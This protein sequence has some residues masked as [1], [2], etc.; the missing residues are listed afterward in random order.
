MNDLIQFP[1]DVPE[2]EELALEADDQLSLIPDDVA[3]PEEEENLEEDESTLQEVSVPVLDN[4][5]TFVW[6]HDK[7]LIV[8]ELNES[9]MNGT[10]DKLMD[11]TLK[12][13]LIRSSDIMIVSTNYWQLNSSDLLAD[14]ICRIDMEETPL[15]LRLTLWYNTEE[16]FASELQEICTVDDLPQRTLPKLDK[17]LIPIMNNDDIEDAADLMWMKYEKSALIHPEANNPWNLADLM[18]LSIMP[19]RLFNETKVRSSLFLEEGSVLV[20]KYDPKSPKHETHGEKT[21]IPV[22]TIVLN[23]SLS[24]FDERMLDI[25]HECFHYENHAMFFRLQKMIQT[26]ISKIKKKKVKIRKDRIPPDVLGIMEYQARRG[27]YALMLPRSAFRT[28]ASSKVHEL[29]REAQENHTYMNEGIAYEEVIRQL[30]A[31]R[32]VPAW[33]VKRRLFQYGH[34]GAKGAHNYVDGKYIAP[35]AFSISPATRLI[36]TY[37][38]DRKNTHLLYRSDKKFQALMQSGDYVWVDGHICAN[39]TQF[40]KVEDGEAQLTLWARAHVDECCL[41]FTQKY[42]EADGSSSYE[43]GKLN[44]V[45]AFNRHYRGFLDRKGVLSDKEYIEA[46]NALVEKVIPLPFPEMLVVLMQYG[47]SRSERFTLE[48]LAEATHLS[49]RTITRM[50]TEKRKEYRRDYVLAVCFAMHLPSWLS[51]ILLEKA[52]FQIPRYGKD[53]YLG[54]L[55]D[56]NFMD[57]VD[58]IQEYLAENHLPLLEIGDSEK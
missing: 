46:K 32:H 26:D 54:E 43:F 39:S 21:A 33:R 6:N 23:T 55:L 29:K 13:K 20:Q 40:I 38:I 50:R 48:A 41:R 58:D 22:N 8:N 18:K 47:N 36:D 12:K 17:Y 49:T 3:D 51:E 24:T 2:A 1:D 45:E 9:L 27:A 34:L 57:T 16:G 52:G 11:T 30:S 4:M 28:F 53:G 10:L 14:L 44:S 25:Y 19:L 42:T 35:F 31:T 7:T 15:S 56:C 37:V 5:D